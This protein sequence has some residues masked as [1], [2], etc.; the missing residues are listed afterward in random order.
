MS[1]VFY[2]ANFFNGM[3]TKITLYLYKW[4][5]KVLTRNTNEIS[6]A[7]TY[8]TCPIYYLFLGQLHL[9]KWWII[10]GI[11]HLITKTNAHVNNYYSSKFSY[12]KITFLIKLKK[13]G[14][15]I[16]NPRNHHEALRQV[17]TV[18]HSF[19]ESM[20]DGIVI[21]GREHSKSNTYMA[22]YKVNYVF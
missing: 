15:K 2:K 11:V 9:T 16:L 20:F 6:I 17:G 1:V 3:V 4:Y 12:E 8:F 10:E 13:S 5:K 21:S 22:T 18:K 19:Y 7:E 14:H